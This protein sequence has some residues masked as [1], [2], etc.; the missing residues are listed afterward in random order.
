MVKAKVWLVISLAALAAGGIVWYCRESTP[1]AK[2]RQ[3]ISELAE[4]ASKASGEGGAANLVKIHNAAELF[5]DP[6]RLEI[7]GTTPGVISAGELPGLL[8]RY[9]SY[10]RQ[11]TVTAEVDEVRL[12]APERGEAEF[13]GTLRGVLKS[14]DSISEVREVHGEFQLDDRGK[15]RISRLKFREILTR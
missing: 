5:T 11:A 10:F 12:V 13:T 2:M 8:A 4:Y 15:W 7:F 14:G 3:V 6:V 1:E 9:R